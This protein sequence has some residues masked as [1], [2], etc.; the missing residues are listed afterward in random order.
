[1]HKH[2]VEILSKDKKLVGLIN[3]FHLPE[4]ELENDIYMIL[5]DSIVSQ[6][7]SVTVAN[8]IFERFINLFE[9]CNPSPK[10]LLEIDIEELRGVGLSYQKA[11]YIKNIGQHWIENKHFDTDWTTMSDEEIIA[12]LVQIKGVGIWTVQMVLIFSLMRE[13]VFPINDLGVRNG[14]LY[15]YDIK[16]EGKE[17]YKKMEHLAAKWAPYRS[18]GARLMWKHYDKVKG[19]K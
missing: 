18:W 15:L 4:L 14:M 1:M 7:L 13:D 10:R 8:K 17:Q 2:A 5:L 19:K 16:E 11:N 9:D 12:D 3:E 6:Q